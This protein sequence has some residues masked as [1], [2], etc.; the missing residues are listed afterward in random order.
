MRLPRLRRSS[1]PAAE[2]AAELE[3]EPRW[4]YPWEL[5]PGL[6]APILADELETVHST[7]R[8]L[9]EGP[10]RERLAEA[11][12]RATALDL[13]CNEGYFSHLLLE[14]GA[15]R[16]VGIDIRD[17]HIRR[18]TLVRDHFGINPASLA[19]ELGDVFALDAARLGTFDVVLNLGLIYHVED[20]VG[21]I[22]RARERTAPGGL[23]V[24]ESQLTRQ[25]EPI[26]HGWGQSGSFEQAEASFAARLE[27]DQ[28]SNT[29]ASAGGV[30]SLIP[31]RAALELSMR[32]AGLE[33]VGFLIPVAG[34]N[35][36]YVL[37]DR[38]IAVGRAPA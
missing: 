17:V 22:R 3:A 27:L 16:V 8:D 26:V 6:R 13:A 23:C 25:T 28:A 35:E 14:W 30:V 11:G 18:A 24:V 5:Q 36:Q 9:I 29:L 15:A 10:V 12:E 32:A 19:L 1:A 31:N 4:M 34:Q 2:L 21:A 20:P 37:G 7:R 33:D 38:A